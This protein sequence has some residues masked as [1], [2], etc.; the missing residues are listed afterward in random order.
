MLKTCSRF[1]A[2]FNLPQIVASGPFRGALLFSLLIWVIDPLLAA[3]RFRDISFLQQL[4]QPTPEE[5]AFRVAISALWLLFGLVVGHIVVRARLQYR[6]LKQQQEQMQQIIASEP[7]CVKT[8]A[9]DGTLLDM[10]PAGLSIIAADSIEQVRN[11]SVYDLI[12][13]EDREAYIE[14]NRRIFCGESAQMEY[15]VLDLQGGRKRVDSHAVP[16]WDSDG[17][18]KAH[19]AITRDIS[20]FKRYQDELKQFSVVV[21]QC[22]TMVMITDPQARITYVNPRFCSVTGYSRAECLGQNPRMLNSGHHDEAFYLTLWGQISQGLE[23][24]GNVQNQRKNGDL[25]WASVVISPIRNELGEIS[26]YLC[27]QED[28]TEAHQM[29][30][31]LEYQASH[32]MLTGLI[33]RH[34]FE[35][36]ISQ[37][38]QQSQLDLS[39][40]AVFFLDVDQ[41]KLINDSCGHEA[42]DQL[43]RQLGNLM[44]SQVRQHDAVARLGGDEFAI[45]LEHC[46]QTEALRLAEQL[47][48]AVENFSFAWDEQQF[49]ITVS[50]GVV[51]LDR[52]WPNAAS[53]LSQADS[54]CYTAKDLGRNRTFQQLDEAATERRHGEMLWIN[55]IHQG[56]EQN[57]F[58]LY[59]QEI[60]GL[61]PGGDTHYEVLIRYRD[62]AGNIIPPGA[63]LPPAERYGLSPKLDRWV[64]QQVCAFLADNPDNELQLSVNLS[65]LSINDKDFLTFVSNTLQQYRIRPQQLCFEITETAAISNLAE[66]VEF[67]NQMKALG[68]RFALDD[69]GSG[70]SSFGYLRNLPVD[71]VKIDGIF[72]KDLAENEIDLAMVRSI[73][74]IG[75][76]MGKKTIAEFV[77]TDEIAQILRQL[78]VDYAQG[79]GI[80]RPQPIESLLQPAD[81]A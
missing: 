3:W 23:W 32:C 37:R 15:D 81:C 68:C 67:I 5:I 69:F 70:L 8:V 48:Q 19:L 7:E 79:Y 36:L 25:Y 63:F 10:N 44:Q 74:D 58:C 1:L 52:S 27:T 2:E 45:L 22:A 38:L 26:H 75:H 78:G 57:R 73:N 76:L 59:Q 51:S 20:E 13:P 14:F 17:Q 46:S 35:Q 80:A 12:A 18:V 71:F 28:V 6:Q 21:E 47:R 62:E 33:N 65:G 55:R 64:L 60:A 4:T 30:R 53:V 72:V 34:R 40:H 77:E 50:I 41:F 9:E 39:Q 66:A 49:K 42:G 11:A 31:Q 29:T 61:Q 43:L 56:I 54:S 16:L 24:R